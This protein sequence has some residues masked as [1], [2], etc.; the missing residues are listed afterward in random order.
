MRSM[1]EVTQSPNREITSHRAQLGRFQSLSP[2]SLVRPARVHPVLVRAR[3]GWC[4]ALLPKRALVIDSRAHEARRT[5]FT[6]REA[7]FPPS[8]LLL[9][10]LPAPFSSTT[11]TT[12]T[13]KSHDSCFPSLLTGVA[14]STLF[15]DT[16]TDLGSSHHLASYDTGWRRVATRWRVPDIETARRGNQGTSRALTTPPRLHLGELSSIRASLSPSCPDLWAP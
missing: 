12:S 11:S 15:Y 10:P 3:Q 6:G 14:L 13:A 7:L 8:T 16:L 5:F 4:I 2:A 9:H 1:P